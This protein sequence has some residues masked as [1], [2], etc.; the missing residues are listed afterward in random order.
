MPLDTIKPNSHLELKYRKVPRNR[1]IEFDIEAS[2]PVTTFVVDDDG[3]R[4]YKTKGSDVY[5]YYGGFPHRRVHRDRV[6]FPRDFDGPWYLI[7][8][9]DSRTE[10]VS[11]GYEV[12]D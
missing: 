2:A 3:L 11:V 8:Q 9:N 1:R 5:S 4:E 6:D 7:I 10:S 12:Y